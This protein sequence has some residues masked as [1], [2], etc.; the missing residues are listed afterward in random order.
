MNKRYRQKEPASGMMR[1][2]FLFRGRL[3]HFGQDGF[4]SFVNQ[5]RTF[6][7]ERAL[8][9]SR[10]TFTD[11]SPSPLC[12][13]FFGGSHGSVLLTGS[14]FLWSSPV[15]NQSLRTS[16]QCRICKFHMQVGVVLGYIIYSVIHKSV[17]HFKNSQQIDCATD[18]SNSYADRE[19]N[20]PS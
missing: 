13:H 18:H 20:S 15:T 17:K 4:K 1:S 6:I 8:F 12:V 3:V 11:I 19:R 7:H 2:G 9:N 14:K 5:Q 16:L 10:P